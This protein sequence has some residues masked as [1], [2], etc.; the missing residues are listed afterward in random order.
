[1]TS[2]TYD[3]VGRIKTVTLPKP[4]A[5][6]TLSFVT[7]Y[8]YD[9]FDVIAACLFSATGLWEF[10]YRWTKDLEAWDKDPGRIKAVHRIDETWARSIGELF[11]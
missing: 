9:Q 3:A 1:V 7:T 2:Y 5:S 6:S 11:D 10:R 4:T 8:T